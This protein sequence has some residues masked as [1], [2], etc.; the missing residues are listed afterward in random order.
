MK[1]YADLAGNCKNCGIKS[2]RDNNVVGHAWFKALFIDHKVPDGENEAKYNPDDYKFIQATVYDNKVLMENNPEYVDNLES[3]PED[4]RRAHLYGD[5]DVY[6]GQYFGEWRRD[7]H[8]IKPF[9]IP[10][11]W[12]R[13]VT[14]DYGLDMLA[15]YWI[16]MD[17]HGKAYVYREVQQPD[18]TISQASAIIKEEGG[19]DDVY[20][21]LAPPDLFNRR[22]ET[23]R[24]A[25]EIFAEN[26]LILTKSNN[27]RVQG[28]YD[29][30]EWLTPYEDEF[31]E[32]T[33]KLVVFNNCRGLIEDIPMLIRDTKNP[34]DVADEPHKHT[35]GPDAIRG[36]IAG[37]PFA[38]A[39]P[40]GK[41]AHWEPDMWD[42]YYVASELGKARLIQKWGNP[43]D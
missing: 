11:N 27:N 3:L 1:T 31:G 24:S 34:N 40:S 18:L 9:E 43:F 20:T 16:A 42:D 39:K 12:R 26:G 25:A 21:Y 4:M 13:Y 38:T 17:T 22:Q 2:P 35:H 6:A 14:L 10:K 33:A 41:K 19:N 30:K 32:K 36:F 28:W 15:V 29:M 8:V 7:I 37:R 5:W 23:G